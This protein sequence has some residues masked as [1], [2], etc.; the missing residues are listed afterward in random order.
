MK[1][2]YRIAA[3]V[4]KL[5]LGNPE[6][7]AK[8]ILGSYREAEANGAVVVAVP[9]LAL[10]GY[11]CGDLFEQDTLL[12][13]AMEALQKIAEGTHSTILICGIPYKIGHALFNA[14]AVLQNGKIRGL[15][16]KEFL[17]DSGVYYEKRQ[18]SPAHELSRREIHCMGE[19][20]PIGKDLIF[21]IDGCFQFGVE[22]CE[23]LWAVHS[24]SIDLALNGAEAIFNLSASNAVAGKARHREKLV[25]NASSKLIAAYLYVGAGIGESTSD[26]VFD[27]Q[28]LCAVNGEIV[29]QG[30]RFQKESQIIYCDFRPRLL[31]HHR[32][33][34]TSFRSSK[35]TETARYIMLESGG[36]EIEPEYCQIRRHPY[37]PAE[38][39]ER[40]EYFE[41]IL[42]I[43]AAGLARR[44]EYTSSKKMLIGVS[45]GL[46]S[47][48]ALLICAR[49]TDR[50]K[51]P[52]KSIVGVTM[53][54][55]GT[56]S[57][58]LKAAIDLMNALGVSQMNIP[59]GQEVSVH[60]NGIGHAGKHDITFENAQ[61][62]ERTKVLMDLANTLGGIVIGTGDLSELALGWCTYNADQMA[63]YCVNASLPK[64][65]VKSIVEYLASKDDG[66]LKGILVDIAARPY[67]PELTPGAP[68][69][70]QQIG[71]YE[72]HDFFLWNFLTSGESPEDMLQLAE[73]AFK[74]L[75]TPDEC[76]KTLA[77]FLRRFF[78]QQFKR[79]PMPDGPKATDLSIS[80]RGDWR[81]P[82]DIEPTLWL[83]KIANNK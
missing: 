6:W 79:D 82:A 27:G 61:A 20:I 57:K 18:F 50:M 68:P 8:E 83:S 12:E 26:L 42:D 75:I 54:G 69:T 17:P 45:G 35:P 2:F 73:Y 51:I 55:M 59:I 9:E 77:I 58:S 63:M 37:I 13:A 72:L 80:P 56:G 22:I 71:S 28:A 34:N 78:T 46:D 3:S 40:E 47:A 62:R 5:H 14:A 64:T 11:T 36:N 48:L 25:C 43:L 41:E 4:P 66:E 24:P 60:L 31:R 38:Q 10:T 67:S 30:K 1:G 16:V 65:L 53:P 29:V 15:A 7:N 39:A 70:E 21:D 49:C 52:R 19:D 81:M 23:D 44:M 32:R 33:K 74:G 76:K